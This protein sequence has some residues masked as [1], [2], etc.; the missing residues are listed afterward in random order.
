[1]CTIKWLLSVFLHKRR[2]RGQ[3]YISKA[4][5]KHLLLFVVLRSGLETATHCEITTRQL[6][7]FTFANWS[8]IFFIKPILY[9]WWSYFTVSQWTELVLL[10]F[11]L[12][13]Q[14]RYKTG[15]GCYN[16]AGCWR[17]DRKGWRSG[18]T[19]RCR[20]EMVWDKWSGGQPVGAGAWAQRTSRKIK[21]LTKSINAT[22]F[23]AKAV[24]H[25]KMEVIKQQSSP[26]L[27]WV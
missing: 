1:M 6:A 27:S 8:L 17:N 14:G 18:T 10:I 25:S 24:K 26:G 23:G 4:H 5:L 15:R 3:I 21:T 11:R 20:A 22:V 9:L 12:C 2:C 16:L 7:L 13:D 19:E